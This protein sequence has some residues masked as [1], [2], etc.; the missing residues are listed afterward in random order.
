MHNGC[1][2]LERID[3]L[4]QGHFASPEEQNAWE[5][6]LTECAEY[7]NQFESNFGNILYVQELG[8]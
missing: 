3:S 7:R 6:H 1:P 2:D 5:Q 8:L 4:L